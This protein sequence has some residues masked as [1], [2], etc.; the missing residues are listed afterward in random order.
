MCT[1]YHTTTTDRAAAI[2]HDG[3]RDAKGH[4]GTDIELCG[5]WLSDQALDVNEGVHGDTVLVVTLS[6]SLS[7]LAD[8]ELIEEGK[9]YREW[10][11]PA[12]LVNRCT[13]VEQASH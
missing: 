13:R 2:L 8:Y 4:Y 12:E 3:F 7:D 9:P 5:V 10:C 11:I 1:L 6:V